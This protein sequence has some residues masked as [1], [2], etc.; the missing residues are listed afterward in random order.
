MAWGKVW[1]K[2][3]IYLDPTDP[4]GE[5]LSVRYGYVMR[6]ELGVYLNVGGEKFYKVNSHL[7]TVGWIKEG[8]FVEYEYRYDRMEDCERDKAENEG[9]T[10]CV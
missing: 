3:D 2:T 10:E 8:E 6:I 7:F 4:D 1:P 9:P 5:K